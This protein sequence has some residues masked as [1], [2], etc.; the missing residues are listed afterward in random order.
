[1]NSPAFQACIKLLLKGG[2]TSNEILKAALEKAR[3]STDIDYGI[4]PHDA[5]PEEIIIR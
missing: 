3:K 5:E 2:K 1:L 4:I